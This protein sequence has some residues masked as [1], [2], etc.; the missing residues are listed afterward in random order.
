M[1]NIHYT[2]FPQLVIPPVVGNKL[3]HDIDITVSTKLNILTFKINYMC[4]H[5]LVSFGYAQWIEPNRSSKCLFQFH[6]HQNKI[7]FLHSLPNIWSSRLFWS[8]IKQKCRK[9]S[10]I[11]I[12]FVFPSLPVKLNIISKFI[13]HLSFLFFQVAVRILW[14][15]FSSINLL[16]VY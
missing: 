16:F 6:F 5:E 3:F 4:Q 13:A 11:I 9:L 14:P 12:L 1:Y 10:F 8:F 7:P 2:I 15:F